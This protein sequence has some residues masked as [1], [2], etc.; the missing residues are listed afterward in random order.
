MG[1]EAAA[2]YIEKIMSER[3]AVLF[4]IFILHEIEHGRD[5]RLLKD[6]AMDI[7]SYFIKHPQESNSS[8]GRKTTFPEMV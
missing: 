3:H 2:S 5:I 7:I 6:L 8:K 4:T 1:N